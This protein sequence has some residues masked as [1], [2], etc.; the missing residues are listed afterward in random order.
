MT[1][2]TKKNKEASENLEALGKTSFGSKIVERDSVLLP[3]SKKKKEGVP[4]NF[5][6]LLKEIKDKI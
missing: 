6:L 5:D 2:L 3:E 4:V 1:G